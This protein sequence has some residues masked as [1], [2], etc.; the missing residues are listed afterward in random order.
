MTTHWKHGFSWKSLW[1]NSVAKGKLGS[2]VVWISL[3]FSPLP[4]QRWAFVSAIQILPWACFS[5]ELSTSPSY[6]SSTIYPSSHHLSTH[7]FICPSLIRKSTHSLNCN[8]LKSYCVPGTLL[9]TQDALD[10]VVF[11]TRNSG[12]KLTEVPIQT[13]SLSS[14][15]V[16]NPSFDHPKPWFPYL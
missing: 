13:L 8:L 10:P 12:V 9:G 2:A 15:V 7:P 5:P 14:C 1:I 6:L 3:W 16:L 4:D 11:K